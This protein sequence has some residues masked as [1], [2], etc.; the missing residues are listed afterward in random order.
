MDKSNSK[1]KIVYKCIKGVELHNLQNFCNLLTQT[2]KVKH[3]VSVSRHTARTYL[4]ILRVPQEMTQSRQ[5][6]R[7]FERFLQLASILKAKNYFIKT[8]ASVILIVL[9]LA[10]LLFQ[11][12]A[13]TLINSDMTFTVDWALKTNY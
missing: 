7:V 12:R 2:V 5:G 4:G 6:L 9:L 13:V 11:P 1:L 8:D 10:C 3:L